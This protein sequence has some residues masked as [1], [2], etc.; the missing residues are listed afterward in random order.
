MSVD[1]HHHHD[2]D[3]DEIL[4]CFCCGSA[5]GIEE[6][7]SP[8]EEI[9]NFREAIHGAIKAEI[10]RAGFVRSCLL[11]PAVAEV[12]LDLVFKEA[13]NT[14]HKYGGEWEDVEELFKSH[15]RALHE[16]FEDVRRQVLEETEKRNEWR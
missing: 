13:M 10:N 3:D 2:H 5:T 7:A 1:D 16:G 12:L 6:I 8:E 14:L 4:H 15:K 9:E 11:V